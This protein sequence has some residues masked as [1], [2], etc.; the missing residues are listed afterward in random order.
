MNNRKA[1]SIYQFKSK[2]G[3]VIDTPVQG[4]LGLLAY[5]DLGLIAWRKAKLKQFQAQPDQR[6]AQ[7]RISTDTPHEHKSST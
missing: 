7:I 5:G 4:C 6:S 3:H 2:D 1:G